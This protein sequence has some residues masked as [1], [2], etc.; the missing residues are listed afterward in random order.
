MTSPRP[1]MSVD[2]RVRD[3]VRSILLWSFSHRRLTPLVHLLPPAQRTGAEG[4][5]RLAAALRSVLT[6]TM[7]C[8][9]VGAYAGDMLR[10]MV[11]YAPRGRHIAWEPLPYMA[12]RLRKSFPTVDVRAAALSDCNGETAFTHVRTQP[13]YSGILPRTYPG[14]ETIEVI[15]V[16]MQ[17]LDDALPSGYVPN[18]LK[19][20]VEGAELQVLRGGAETLR[21]CRPYVFFEHGRGGADHYGTTPHELFDFLTNECGLRISDIERTVIYSRDA[22]AAANDRSDFLAY[23]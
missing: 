1:S 22:F 3:V 2:G 4:Q 23:P 21:R 20:D 6:P 18:L 16:P 11:R 9:D 10:V 7:N 14:K 5:L 13:T 8:I 15:T 12:R 19:V 17:R